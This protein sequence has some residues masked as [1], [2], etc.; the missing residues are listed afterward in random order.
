MRVTA[1]LIAQSLLK[2]GIFRRFTR[3]IDLYWLGILIPGKGY[4]RGT[5]MATST[6]KGFLTFGLLSIPVR[7]F[8]AARSERISLNQIHEVCHSRIKMPLFCPTCDRKVERSEIV[9]GYEYDKDQ[10]L[11]F[12]EEELDEIEPDSSRTMEIIE[13]V[14]LDEIDPLYFD[15]SYYM[16][17]E[18]EGRKAYHLLLKALEDTGYSAI[19]KLTMHQREHTVIIRPHK[20]GMTLHTMFYQSE[21]RAVAEYGR[22]EGIEV[23]AAEKKLASQLIENL[24]TEF[25]P[26]KFH[27]EYHESM[28][29]LIAAK[30]KGNKIAAVHHASREPVADMMTALKNSLQQS[31]AKKAVAPKKLPIRAVPVIAKE[32]KKTG[33]KAVS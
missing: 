11:L 4:K 21:I 8:A 31:A 29:A 14:K 33:K 23:S 18:Q 17:P 10:Y 28:Q 7:L 16:T 2:I 13:F 5:A 15:A 3:L 26:E 6:W 12:K 27:D 20:D 22:D 25:E 32:M 30:Q 1:A 24:A 19:A 9:K